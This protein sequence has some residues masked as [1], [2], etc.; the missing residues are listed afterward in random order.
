[1]GE[2][3]DRI[4]G[5]VTRASASATGILSVWLWPVRA[6]LV[7]TGLVTSVVTTLALGFL[8]LTDAVARLSGDVSAAFLLTIPGLIAAFIVRPGEHSAVSGLLLGVRLQIAFAGFIAYAA[9]LTA[10]GGFSD[11]A[12]GWIWLV[13]YVLA[14]LTTISLAIGYIGISPALPDVGPTGEIESG[15]TDG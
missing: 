2:A 11:V 5:Y 15:V 9:A 1:M 6:G 14:S 4:H 13:L 3:G 12:L 10:L 8:L 7:R